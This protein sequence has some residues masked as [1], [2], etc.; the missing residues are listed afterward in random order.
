MSLEFCDQSS[1]GTGS[2]HELE[3]A[4][5]PSISSS[6][7]SS[8]SSTFSDASAH[9]SI[10]TSVSDDFRSTQEDLRE[11]DRICA[12]PH[13][14]YQSQTGQVKYGDLNSAVAAHL[15]QA[16]AQGAPTYADVTSLPAVH[17]QHPRR[18]SI[19]KD[20]RPPSLVRQRDRK[21]DFVD[22]LVGKQL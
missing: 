2:A 3:E 16:C 13:L 9:S 7:G 8:R 11:Q 12:H 6:T 18:C 19:S 17:R 5:E 1:I 4:Y 21:I 14:Q 10:A 20:R 22:N 15:G